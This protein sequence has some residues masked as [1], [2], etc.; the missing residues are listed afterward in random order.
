M[1]SKA[2]VVGAYQKKLE[3][4]AAQP[5]VDHLTCVVPPSWQEPGGREIRLE[6][7]H[8]Q[9]YELRV[10]PIRR[11]GDFH[12]F[13]WVG[14]GKVMRELRPDVVHVDEEPY[15]FATAH[16]T[17][18]AKRVGARPLFFTW[19]N[20]LRRYPPPFSLFEHYVFR[21]CRAALVGNAEAADVLRRKGFRGPT[22]RIPQFGID[23][24]L[25]R[26]GGAQRVGDIPT[27]G[28]VARLVEEKGPLVLLDALAKVSSDWRLHVVGSGPLLET[29]QARASTLGL[30]GRVTWEAA[31]RSTDIP[32][33]LQQ[34]DLL[35]LPS[36]T[37]PHWKEQF[38]RILVEAMA[39]EV[40]VIGST[41]GEIPHVVG[42]AGVL[43]PEGDSTA[44]AGAVSRLLNDPAERA[45][46]GRRGRE[47]ALALFTHRR[48][49][50]ETVAV[51]RQV[52]GQT[53]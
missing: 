43:V 31:V 3:E 46:R 14:L 29:C 8:P 9:G 22:A 38:G 35:V 37:R 50:E 6:R 36:L 52:L 32:R 23:P 53:P 33:R 42:D 17:W 51:Y 47:R 34:L 27:I 10:L 16:A 11:N 39:C 19:Q 20:L 44:L 13:H 45:E 24:E 12:L 4:I 21:H 15:N 28:Y 41:C 48:I 40:P 30:A 25:F 1:V 26:P 49:A 18:Q 2:L 5:G 7:E